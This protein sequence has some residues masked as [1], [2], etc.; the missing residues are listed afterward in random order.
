MI[1]DIVSKRKE[2]SIRIRPLV[3]DEFI[4]ILKVFLDVR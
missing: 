2:V 1:M 3:C 4:A